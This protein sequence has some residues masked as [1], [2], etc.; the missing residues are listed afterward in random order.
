M[1]PQLPLPPAP[2]NQDSIL[3]FYDFSF[4]CVCVW[5]LLALS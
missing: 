1:S 3:Y 5:G 2:D 4:L